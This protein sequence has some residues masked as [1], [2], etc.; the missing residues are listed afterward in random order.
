MG[1]LQGRRLAYH[2][3]DLYWVLLYV[4]RHADGSGP[5][6]KQEGRV[7]LSPDLS[8]SA[9]CYLQQ[10][11]VPVELSSEGILGGGGVR[12][13]Q[14]CLRKRQQ[15]AHPGKGHS[16]R[17]ESRGVSWALEDIEVR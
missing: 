4:R 5:Q 16:D 1:F 11:P 12:G 17:L 13:T 9:A 10:G 14:S 3:L 2:L 8:L 15:D 7:E 6:N